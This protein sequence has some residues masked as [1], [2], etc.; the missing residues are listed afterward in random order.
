VIYPLIQNKILSVLAITSG[1]SQKAIVVSTGFSER[2][3]RNNLNY[4]ESSG[5]ILSSRDFRN[6]NFKKYYLEVG[7]VV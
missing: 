3:I 5:L 7:V 6:R 1:I 4:L 2:C